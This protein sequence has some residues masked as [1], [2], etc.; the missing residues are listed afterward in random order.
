M[1]AMNLRYWVGGA[2]IILGGSALGLY[3]VITHIPPDPQR[4]FARPQILF[5]LLTFLTLGA[6]T[7]PVSA[8]FNHR[9]ANP[10]WTDRD[11]VR[12]LRQGGLV[13]G[14]GILLL[15]MQLQQTLSWPVGIVLVGV[16]VLIEIYFITRE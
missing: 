5:F 6:G 1:G 16:L 13:G 14:L 9:F 7:V 8:Y 2:I 10:A 15:Y 11:R 4:V 3:Y 12:L